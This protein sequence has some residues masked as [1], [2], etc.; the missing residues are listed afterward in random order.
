MDPGTFDVQHLQSLKNLGIN[1]IS[2]GVQS[3]HDPILE[4]IG[5]VHRRKDI[6]HAIECIRTVFGNDDDNDDDNGANYSLD[7]ISGLPG[8]TLDLWKETIQT[9]LSLAPPP[10]HLSVYDLQ[11]EEGTLFRK[12]Y[13]DVDDHDDEDEDDEDRLGTVRESGANA[14]VNVPTNGHG[15]LPLP[16]PEDC[17]SMYKHASDFLRSNGFEHYEISSYARIKHNNDDKAG[18][19]GIRNTTTNTT[20]QHSFRSR[21]N[22][23]YW[24]LDSEWYA[25]G[26]SATSFI[27]KKRFA[28]PPKMADYV[29]WVQ[30]S[31]QQSSFAENNGAYDWLWS[32]HTEEEEQQEN[33]DEEILL[34][35]IMTRL[36]TKEGLDL[37]WIAEN[38]SKST[39]KI[40]KRAS[41]ALQPDL[42][43]IDEESADGGD[44]EGNIRLIDPEGF[45]FSNYII[46]N[47]FAEITSS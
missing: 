12:L 10:N 20:E 26:L 35:T 27:G 18:S 44:D 1:R 33:D 46:S 9:A 16:S 21:H 41:L 45:L 25:V 7:L 6:D 23:I 2:L 31:Q 39:V 29:K 22:Q 8:L 4:G 3:F 28:R 17:A 13:R 11:I 40:I 30:A 5:R 36:R 47:I 15:V 43:R 24:K 19:S 38:Y 32:N 34:D 14:N 37:N 42:V